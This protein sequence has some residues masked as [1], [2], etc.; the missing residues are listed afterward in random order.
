M[1]G[2]GVRARERVDS[3]SSR[4]LRPQR[5]SHGLPP[6]KKAFVCYLFIYLF[7]FGEFVMMAYFFHLY[8]PF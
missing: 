1:Q 2:G 7:P 5:D 8:I 6:T 4:F 3:L